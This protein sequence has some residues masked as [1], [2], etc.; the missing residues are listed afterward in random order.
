MKIKFNQSETVCLR[1]AT[2]S[3]PKIPV[4][5][6]QL[7]CIALPMY[8]HHL[9]IFHQF[10]CCCWNHKY[11]YVYK[12][13]P[14]FLHKLSIEALV[15]YCMLLGCCPAGQALP[16]SQVFSCFYFL[17]QALV[18]FFPALLYSVPSIFQST[19]TCSLALLGKASSHDSTNA[20][21]HCRDS[22]LMGLVFCPTQPFVCK[23]YTFYFGFILTI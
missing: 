17:F 7:T 13:V 22:M 19:L 18:F 20:M 1:Q 2:L 11:V 3:V 9:G 21:L 15:V 10:F 16:Q 12:K 23:P 5:T 8:S 4:E 14:S 6:Y